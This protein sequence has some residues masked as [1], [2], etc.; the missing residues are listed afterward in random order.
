MLHSARDPSRTPSRITH[1][2]TGMEV[3]GVE[4]PEA[5]AKFYRKVRA[6]FA[7][8]GVTIYCAASPGPEFGGFYL[9]GQQAHGLQRREGWPTASANPELGEDT[10]AEEVASVL[11]A[12]VHC[13]AAEMRIA[14]L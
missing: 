12:L 5:L 3:L 10:P 1:H 6:E 7:Q 2:G 8:D 14:P 9:E 13:A 11:Q 4:L